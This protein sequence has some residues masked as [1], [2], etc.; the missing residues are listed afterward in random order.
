ML[1]LLL[2]LLLLTVDMEVGGACGE[3]ELTACATVGA[4]TTVVADFAVA[5]AIGAPPPVAPGCV[6]RAD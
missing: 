2:L 5:T 4:A 1:L 3:F 6:V